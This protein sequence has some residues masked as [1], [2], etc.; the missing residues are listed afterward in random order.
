MPS[1]S[2]QAL[3]RPTALCRKSRRNSQ[4][5]AP[6][7]GPNSVPTPPIAGCTTSWPEV[8]N[9]NASGGMK[10]CS[11]P[12]QTRRRGRQGRGDD[13]GGELVGADP[14]AERLGTRSG[15]SRIALRISPT[16][17]RTMRSATTTPAK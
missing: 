15:L 6:T 2:F 4:T 7:S 16:G 11:T 8:S 17:E 5:V 1:T 14:V 10:P 9:E 12:E 3:P 13:E